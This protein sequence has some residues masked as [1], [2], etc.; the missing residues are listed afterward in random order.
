MTPSTVTSRLNKDC[1]DTDPDAPVSKKLTTN[2]HFGQEKLELGV[3][4]LEG[5]MLAGQSNLVFFKIFI[6]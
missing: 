3:S 5:I 6:S 4:F 1:A 2:A